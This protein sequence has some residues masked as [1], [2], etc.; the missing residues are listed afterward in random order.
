[1]K[2]ARAGAYRQTELA[3]WSSLPMRVRIR[4]QMHQHISKTSEF[5]QQPVLD[6]VADTVAVLDRQLCLNL[7]VDVSEILQPRLPHP[8]FFNLPNARHF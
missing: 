8:E 1:M 7:D 6:Q 2:T 3:I 4:L 5:L